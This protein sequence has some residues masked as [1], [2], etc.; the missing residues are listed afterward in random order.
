MLVT[1]GRARGAGAVDAGAVREGEQARLERVAQRRRRRS[2]ARATRGAWRGR[3]ARGPRRRRGRP[4]RG[5][6]PR[7]WLPPRST[8]GDREPGPREERADRLGAA[9]LV[10]REAARVGAPRA[11]S[12]L[13]PNDCTAS[14]CTRA[15]ARCAM[16]IASRHRL[17][18]ARL[19]VDRLEGH[20]AHVALA[21]RALEVLEVDAP[22]RQAR[23][24]SARAPSLRARAP[25]PRARPTGARGGS[26]RARPA[27][28]ARRR[29]AA[30]G[31]SPPCRPT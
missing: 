25:R 26:S 2:S 18:H 21:E 30:R 24:A 3:D 28:A 8:G 13:R 6:R 1:W 20:E 4:C 23:A 11:T 16:A 5:A 27:L 17:H 15:P 22:L 29:C 31:C 10:G 7:S 12:S 9:H 14:T 19:G